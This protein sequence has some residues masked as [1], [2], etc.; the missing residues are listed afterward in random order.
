MGIMA[1]NLYRSAL[2]D[3]RPL[4]DSQRQQILIACPWMYGLK[5]SGAQV[6][7]ENAA[8]GERSARSI[9]NNGNAQSFHED[10]V[11]WLR[12]LSCDELV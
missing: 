10:R 8:I 6:S 4:L 5:S 3:Y 9:V 7:N 11:G 2:M 12:L 1:S